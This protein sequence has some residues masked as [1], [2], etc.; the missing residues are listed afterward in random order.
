MKAAISTRYGTTDV[1]AP[2]SSPVSPQPARVNMGPVYVLGGTVLSL[3]A[4]DEG[5]KRRTVG[6]TCSCVCLI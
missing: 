1:L 4:V 5:R 2:E 6:K 3:V